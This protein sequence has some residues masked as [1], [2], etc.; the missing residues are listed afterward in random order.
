MTLNRESPKQRILRG[1]RAGTIGALAGVV[2]FELIGP[3]VSLSVQAARDQ[4]AAELARTGITPVGNATVTSGAS[5]FESPGRALLTAG[6]A[7][8]AGLLSGVA[9]SACSA[10]RSWIPPLAGIVIGV[11]ALAIVDQWNEQWLVAAA[12]GW[13]VLVVSWWWSGRPHRTAAAG[14][15]P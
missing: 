6:V 9:L 14:S 5:M 15:P 1:A 13:T 3:N 8:A 7:L 4:A 11:V 12:T 2:V 10:V